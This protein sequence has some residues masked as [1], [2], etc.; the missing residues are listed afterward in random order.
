M[1]I[2]QRKILLILLGCLG[3]VVILYGAYMAF[4]MYFRACLNWDT[5]F[6]NNMHEPEF[7]KEIEGLL[8][9]QFPASAEFEKSEYRAWLDATFHCVFTLPKKDLDLMFPPEKMVSYENVPHGQPPEKVTWH[10][11]DHTML[12]QWSKEWLKG[13]NLD[14]FRV[15]EYYPTSGCYVTV[16]VENP[17]EADENQRVWVYINFMDI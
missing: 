2:N 10:E 11:N 5:V 14:H 15:L 4:D 17:P 16:V 3:A 12:P 8:E 6:T 7:R 1:S 9:F 13:K